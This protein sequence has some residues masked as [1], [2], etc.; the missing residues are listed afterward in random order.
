MATASRMQTISPPPRAA[1]S[2]RSRCQASAQK[3]RAGRTARRR[4]SGITAGLVRTTLADT[5]LLPGTRP[6][7]PDLLQP[8]ALVLPAH[9]RVDV[10]ALEALRVDPHQVR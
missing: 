9:D 5:Q 2:L 1:R 8:V 7:R 10:E 4:G 6:R 3:V